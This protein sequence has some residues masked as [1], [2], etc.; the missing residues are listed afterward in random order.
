MMIIMT[1]LIKC[2]HRNLEI[3]LDSIISF[4]FLSPKIMT[5]IVEKSISYLEG[6][7]SEKNITI[8]LTKMQKAT[9][10]IKDMIKAMELDHLQRLIQKKIKEP[11][12]EEILFGKLKNGGKVNINLKIKKLIFFLS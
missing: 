10:L 6:Q 5:N 9:Y 8:E 4:D 11:L 3:D 1:K 12:A 7:L 2:F